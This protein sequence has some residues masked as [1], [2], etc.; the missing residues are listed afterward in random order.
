MCSSLQGPS[1]PLLKTWKELVHYWSNVRPDIWW[2]SSL[3][4]VSEIL[5]D[6]VWA[7][8]YHVVDK[9]WADMLPKKS[10]SATST[11]PTKSQLTRKEQDGK[12]RNSIGDVWQVFRILQSTYNG[13]SGV[14]LYGAVESSKIKWLAQKSKSLALFWFYTPYIILP[15]IGLVVQSGDTYRGSS[16]SADSNSVISL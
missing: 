6:S 1:S 14:W 7:D 12:Q 2:R 16:N 15:Q 3:F 10:Q 8:E 5:K 4:S 9:I 11:Y 13:W